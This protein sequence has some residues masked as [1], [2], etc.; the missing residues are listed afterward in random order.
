MHQERLIEHIAIETLVLRVANQDL[1]RLRQPGQHLVRRL[2]R[3]DHRILIAAARRFDAGRVDAADRVHIAIKIVKRRV[4]QP[5]FIEVQRI[6]LAVQLFVDHL[7]V[8]QDAVVRTL[9]QRQDTWLVVI[10]AALAV[11][12]Q[13]MP[14]DFLGDRFPLELV[15]RNRANDSV[16]VARRRQKQRDRAGHRD[17]VQHGLVAISIDH[18]DVV[19][20]DDVVPDD[21]VRGRRTVGDEEQMVGAKD[22]SGVALARSYRPGVIEQLPELVDRV[23]N[24]CPQHVF[25]KKLVEHAADRA[26]QKRHAAGVPRAVPRIRAILRIVCQRPEKR[27]RKRFQINPRFA[28]DVARDEFRRVFEHVNE[29]VQLAQQIVR[30]VMRGA[31][32]AVEED[33]NVRISSSNFAYERSQLCDRLLVGM[34]FGELLVVDGQD[35]RRRVALLLREAGDIAKRGDAEDFDALGLDRLGQRANAE[36]AGVLGTKI[37]VDDDDRKA[38]SHGRELVLL[39]EDRGLS[40]QA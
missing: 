1:R 33:R 7:H 3:E 36:T 15:E 13:R 32:L 35:E 31:R 23:A 25:A 29:A 9:R 20:S 11:L 38:K 8:V 21:L 27:R 5:R 19:G 39:A 2:C 34:A 4:R 18:D 14:F 40:A 10:I 17:R 28:D 37:L 6:D 24:V 22:A 30:H 26:L 12:Q 16:M